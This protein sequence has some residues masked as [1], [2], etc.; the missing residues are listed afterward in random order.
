VSRISGEAE[1]APRDSLAAQIFAAGALNLRALG[2]LEEGGV[3]NLTGVL[4]HLLALEDGSGKSWGQR[5]SEIWIASALSGNPRAIEDILDR[6]DKGRPARTSAAVAAPGIDD[7]TASK[8]LE[9][10]C[11][12]G[13]DAT[14]D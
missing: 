11:G 10:L 5:L 4:C 14:G 13:E 9:V 6:T 7:Q 12:R 1:V 3:L 8:I 2:L